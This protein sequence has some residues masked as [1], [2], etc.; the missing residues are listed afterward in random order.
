M[1]SAEAVS[2]GGRRIYLV[3]YL[4]G[5]D[6]SAQP[7]ALLQRWC[8]TPD[9]AELVS[10]LQ[11]REPLISTAAYLLANLHGFGPY[12][13]K[14]AC[15]F[16][17][18]TGLLKAWDRRPIGPGAESCAKYLLGQEAIRDSDHGVWPVDQTAKGHQLYARFFRS[19]SPTLPA[20]AGSPWTRR[21]RSSVCATSLSS[22]QGVCV[23]DNA[24]EC[25]QSRCLH[26]PLRWR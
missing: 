5:A 16:L 9:F 7:R 14:D 24:A 22:A 11:E 10:Q 19:S 4:K 2:A 17:H 8:G 1:H 6:H 20:G 3:P 13:G 25:N 18:L 21:M 26:T 23:S 12:N 15:S